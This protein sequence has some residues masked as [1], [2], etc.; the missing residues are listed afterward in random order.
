MTEHTLYHTPQTNGRSPR[1]ETVSSAEDDENR[2]VGAST[3]GDT[4]RS[5]VR[6]LSLQVRACISC[7][8]LRC[9]DLSPDPPF[10]LRFSLLFLLVSCPFL[11]SVAGSGKLSGYF[12]LMQVLLALLVIAGASSL[13]WAVQ[14]G[15]LGV[16]RMQIAGNGSTASE[17]NW[18]QDR[19][20]ALLPQASIVSLPLTVYRWLMLAW[21]LWLA[22]SVLKW[23][24]WAWDAFTHGERW[25]HVK[26]KLPRLNSKPKAKQDDSIK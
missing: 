1:G 23:S 19:S 24:Q 26:L 3:P 14:Q 11:H 12:N 2:S 25:R 9:R 21:A 6:E 16:P 20:D 22:L 13:L 17:L 4:L 5:F 7:R 18:Y 8:G 10:Q 15:L